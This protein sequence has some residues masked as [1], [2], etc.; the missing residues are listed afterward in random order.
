M[1][2]DFYGSSQGIPVGLM[3]GIPQRIWKDCW[4]SPCALQAPGPHPARW[5]G[6]FALEAE[7]SPANLE[8]GLQE[9]GE[10]GTPAAMVPRGAA[11]AWSC[12]V[13]CMLGTIPLRAGTVT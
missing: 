10:P 4:E 8:I 12:W 3:S 2:M 9:P 7:N 13:G 6:G 11:A 5:L 1:L